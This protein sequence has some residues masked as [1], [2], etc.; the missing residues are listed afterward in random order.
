MLRAMASPRVV[1]GFRFR[2][3]TPPSLHDLSSTTSR[4]LFVATA[5]QAHSADGGQTLSGASDR[6]VRFVHLLQAL[7]THGAQAV[8]NAL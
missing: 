7:D 1:F 8:E 3:G 6:D 4:L 5:L 2:Q